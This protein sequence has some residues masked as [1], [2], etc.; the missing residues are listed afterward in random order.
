MI[1]FSIIIPHKNIPELLE[2]CLASIPQRDDVQVIVV[3]DGSRVPPKAT[4]KDVKIILTPGQNAGAARNVGIEKAC[5]KWLVFADADD[6]FLPAVGEMMDKYADSRADIVFFGNTHVDSDTLAP[7]KETYHAGRIEKFLDTGDQDGLRYGWF[8]PWGKFIRREVVEAN[9]L[10]FREVKFANDVLFSTTTGHAARLIE[11]D[12]T[13][14]YCHTDRADS[15]AGA[16]NVSADSLEVRLGEAME[17]ARF[18]KSVGRS[19]YYD[20]VVVRIWKRLMRIDHTRGKKLLPA[21]KEFLPARKIATLWL[22][23]VF[24]P[25]FVWLRKTF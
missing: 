15:L 22:K 7:L 3:D 18:M 19:G 23:M 12:P 8:V 20:R 2:R 9:S 17:M 13:P 6:F 11:V 24:E 1:N 25:I 14:V 5:G 10:K 21:L 16:K 4:R